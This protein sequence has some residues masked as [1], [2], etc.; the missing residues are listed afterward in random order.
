LVQEN[1]YDEFLRR[2][3]EEA[4]SW[5]IGDPLEAETTLGPV[6]SKGQY[7]R[8]MNYIDIARGEGRVLFGGGRPNG[9]DTGFFIEPTA[10]VDAPNS[11]RICQEEVFGPVAV[12]LPFKDDAHALELA[13][14][15]PFG[16]AGY[17]WSGSLERAHNAALRLETGM[18]WINS[19]FARDLRQ[20]FGGVKDSGQGREGGMFSREFYTETRFASLP[21]APR[22]DD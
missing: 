3:E 9:L 21:L 1:I 20:P 18:I 13:N 11:A 12:I 6:V 2:F 5:V 10:I 14:D 8:I 16:L 19:G 17:I 7:E 4:K 15:S 22:R